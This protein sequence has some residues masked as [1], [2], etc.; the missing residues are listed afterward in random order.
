MQITTV[1]METMM[2]EAPPLLTLPSLIDGRGLD[3]PGGR[4][5]A[6]Q[7]DWLIEKRKEL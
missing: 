4:Q 6:K 5:K 2:L 7:C 1:A 3:D